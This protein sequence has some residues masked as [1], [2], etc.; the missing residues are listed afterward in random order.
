MAV[1]THA[2]RTV[3]VSI[4]RR[5]EEVYRFVADPRNFPRWAKAFCKSVRHVEGRWV[6]ET[7][8]GEMGVRFVEENGLGVLDHFVT[9]S[10][11]EEVYV[12]MRVVAN[13]GGSEVVFTV[14]RL[15]GMSE[16][17]FAE[18]V[19]M[20]ERDLAGLKAVLDIDGV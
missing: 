18:D 9:V 19:G 7:P 2:A 6:I 15:E 12:P 3:G 20:V 4:G 16:E 14:F 13:G 17:R 10:P 5:P 11:G 8:A 1:T